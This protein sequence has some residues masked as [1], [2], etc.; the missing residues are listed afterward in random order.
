MTFKGFIEFGSIPQA[1]FMSSQTN[2]DTIQDE[3]LDGFVFWLMAND[4]QSLSFCHRRNSYYNLE[5]LSNAISIVKARKALGLGR[6][7]KIFVGVA[8]WPRAGLSANTID[9][10]S[11]DMKYALHNLTTIAR[12]VKECELD[13]IAFD[14]ES[15]ESDLWHYAV[16]PEAANHSFAEYGAE[17]KKFGYA[18][19]EEL[20]KYGCDFHFLS[21]GAYSDTLLEIQNNPTRHLHDCYYGLWSYFL[22]GLIDAWGNYYYKSGGRKAGKIILTSELGYGISDLAGAQ[23]RLSYPSGTAGPQFKGNSPW[24]DTVCEF[25]LGTWIDYEPP[26]FTLVPATNYYTPALWK[27]CLEAC[28]DAGCSWVWIYQNDYR[29][30]NPNPTNLIPNDYKVKMFE[31]RAERGLF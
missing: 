7:R 6:T 8:L 10:F 13:G 31:I 5:D 29:L 17:I 16:Q 24:F 30:F 1:T 23:D 26:D 14:H 12:F 9:W 27:S 4:G 22:D 11:P 15:Y 25:G 21:F 28:I 19:V 3:P 2:Y 18:F 20:R